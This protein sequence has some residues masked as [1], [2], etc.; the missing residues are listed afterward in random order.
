MLFWRL[1]SCLSALSAC[2]PNVFFPVAWAN[3]QRVAVVLNVQTPTQLAATK[4]QMEQK[5]PIVKQKLLRS[6]C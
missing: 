3:V 6:L 4:K 1:R 5:L 2:F